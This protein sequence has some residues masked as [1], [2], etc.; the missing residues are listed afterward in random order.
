MFAL[1]MTEKGN[2][3]KICLKA[4]A[5]GFVQVVGIGRASRRLDRFLC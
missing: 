1:V 2:V 3:Y 4:I 5:H